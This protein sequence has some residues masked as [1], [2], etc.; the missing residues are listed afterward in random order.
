MA[1]VP[2]PSYEASNALLF[3]DLKRLIVPAR[4]TRMH[5]RANSSVEKHLWSIGEWEER[6]ARSNRAQ[7]PIP[8]FVDC[9]FACRNTVH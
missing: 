9:D 5:E 2:L 8:G 4:S 1:E 6:V 7:C 3:A